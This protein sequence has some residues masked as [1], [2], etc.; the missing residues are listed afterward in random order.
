MRSSSSVTHTLPQLTRVSSVNT[1]G[2]AHSLD[3]QLHTPLV[4]ACCTVHA[5]TQYRN[6]RRSARQVQRW[7]HTQLLVACVAQNTSKL[8]PVAAGTTP[9]AAAGSAAHDA[10]V[11]MHLGR[12]YTKN[13]FSCSFSLLRLL[14][15]PPDMSF[16]MCLF[17]GMECPSWIPTT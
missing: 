16:H 4:N 13:I 15:V 1:P 10:A 5:C 7:Q 6:G 2:V 3:K 12:V 8:A 17:K 11:N 14:R 9:A